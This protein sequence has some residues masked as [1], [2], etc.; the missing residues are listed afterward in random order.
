MS[1]WAI[2]RVLIL[3]REGPLGMHLGS[4]PFEPPDCLFP[5]KPGGLGTLCLLS[6]AIGWGLAPWCNND[7]MR[8]LLCNFKL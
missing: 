1:F 6:P 2:L 4:F 8:N 3:G 5:Y 7:S